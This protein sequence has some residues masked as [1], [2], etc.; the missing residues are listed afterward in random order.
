MWS[1]QWVQLHKEEWERR[2]RKPWGRATR[3]AWQQP[4]KTLLVLW[5]DPWM[6]W[7]SDW[8][9]GWRHVSENK[10]KE[11]MEWGRRL[12]EEW[13]TIKRESDEENGRK[14]WLVRRFYETRHAGGF[15]AEQGVKVKETQQSN[16]KIESDEIIL[17]IAS[18]PPTA[19]SLYV[20]L[21]AQ[22]ESCLL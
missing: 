11:N 2:R 19:D 13:D 12:K 8:S 22:G 7:R 1:T 17:G 5:W 21:S 3:T 9:W 18:L 10:G 15:T 20:Y 16:M 14:C 4:L 6:K